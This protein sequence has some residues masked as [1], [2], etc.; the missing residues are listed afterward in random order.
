MGSLTGICTAGGTRSGTPWRM[1]GVPGDWDAGR[2]GVAGVPAVI[3]RMAGVIAARWV[4][5]GPNKGWLFILFNITCVR[6]PCFSVF[7]ESRSH[8]MVSGIARNGAWV[9]TWYGSLR[10]AG[11]MVEPVDI[12]GGMSVQS[13][14]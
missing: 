11:I 10:A 13:Y 14:R 4:S 1:R 8:G 3:D 5:T 6:D 7:N 9:Q 12:R 2:R